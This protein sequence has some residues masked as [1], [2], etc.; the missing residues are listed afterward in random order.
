ML[1][2]YTGPVKL[3][4]GWR[5]LLAGY[6]HLVA[7][8]EKMQQEEL[9]LYVVDYLSF[10]LLSL[11]TETFGGLYL[12]ITKQYSETCLRQHLLR[13]SPTWDI[14]IV[15]VPK[16]CHVIT[17]R[18]A[19]LIFFLIKRVSHTGSMKI[20]LHNKISTYLIHF[21]VQVLIFCSFDLL[22]TVSE[23]IMLLVHKG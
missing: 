21:W 1:C 18:A 17:I 19:L 5:L 10:P 16:Y 9:E 2:E 14:R 8:R 22:P 12:Y 23:K 7:F 11:V 20:S 4:W 6:V 13:S 15:L 3:C